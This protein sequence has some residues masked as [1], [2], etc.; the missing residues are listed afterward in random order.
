MLLALQAAV[1][2]LSLGTAQP[3]TADEPPAHEPGE[4]AL[5]VDG[6]AAPGEGGARACGDVSQL[7]HNRATAWGWGLGLAGLPSSKEAALVVVA[8][9][10]LKSI[11]GET[12]S[13][14]PAAQ[15]E[16]RG[17]AFLRHEPG[18]PDRGCSS[19]HQQAGARGLLTGRQSR[20][21]KGLG[22]REGRREDPQ[23]GV[24]S[25][26]GYEGRVTVGTT[27]RGL[28]APP[29]HTFVH[30]PLAQSCCL[31]TPPLE[32]PGAPT[33]VR[34]PLPSPCP[35]APALSSGT[36]QQGAGPILS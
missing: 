18:P 32:P 12:W 2:A 5:G 15:A 30:G 3:G 10:Q 29:G 22:S 21:G 36:A 24:T 28:Q 1:P 16:G 14:V 13:P 26:R 4:E 8:S 33:A 31:W 9:A 20:T 34:S 17:Q 23:C 19:R 11:S 7:L 35:G 6:Q 25:R 27:A